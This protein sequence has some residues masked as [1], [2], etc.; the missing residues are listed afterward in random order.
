[1]PLAL[2]E[3]GVALRHAGHD[4][5]EFAGTLPAINGLQGVRAPDLLI[6]R[7]GYPAGSPTGLSL[8]WMALMKC[9]RIKIVI[10]GDPALDEYTAGLGVFHPHPIDVPRLVA[11]VRRL[12]TE[13]E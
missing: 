9:P 8:S 4:A 3:V 5:I 13:R 12:R 10:T 1:M 7:A 2:P 6:A 11:T